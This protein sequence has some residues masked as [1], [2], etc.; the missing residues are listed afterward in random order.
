MIKSI[1]SKLNATIIVFILVS[2]ISSCGGGDNDVWSNFKPLTEVD[3]HIADYYLQS[4]PQSAASKQGNPSIYVDFSDGIIQAYTFNA[5]NKEIISALAQKLADKNDWYG[6]GKSFGD[7]IGKLEFADDRDLFNKV[8]TPTNYIDLMA[9]IEKAIEKIVASNNDA[10][11][12]TDFEEYT[13]DGKE[14]LFAYAKKYFIDWL[15]KGNSITFFYT[16]Y[17]EVNTKSKLSTDKNLYY[18][19]FTYGASSESGLKY[20]FIDALNGR[21]IT[22]QSFDLNPNPY[23]VRN[24]YGGK[25]NTGIKSATFSKFV[26]SNINALADSKLPYEFIGLNKAWNEDLKKQIDNYVVKVDQ[27]DFIGKLFM[28]A[29][30]QQAYQLKKLKVVVTNISDDFVKFARSNEAKKHAPVLTKDAG[31]NDVWNDASKKDPITTAC[32]D[33]KTNQL[34]PEWV[35]APSDLSKNVWAEVFDINSKIFN[36]H[37]KND[38]ANVE[39]ITVLH[40]NYKLKNVTKEDA[41]IRVDYVIDE[42]LPNIAN[43]QLN[44]F[45]WISAIKKETGENNSLYESVRNALQE[46]K[47]S[48]VV[49]SYFIKL[50]NNTK[51]AEK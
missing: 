24:D 25:E 13:P 42:A 6:L 31:K 14:Q 35:Y 49:Y 15:N 3:K 4:M 19:V 50:K 30:N 39:L 46:V 36:D 12:I 44:D 7:G 28:N 20:K 43:T 22:Y 11:L 5:Q 38:P 37:L 9:P 41:L 8:T 33:K 17:K 29:S 47:P 18:A 10:I 23:A 27:G 51:E 34:K 48:G 16:K 32:F 21:N 26:N 45:K 40:S 2:F 1:F